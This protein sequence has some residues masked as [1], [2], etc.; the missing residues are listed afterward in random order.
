MTRRRRIDER[1]SQAARMV[2]A[3]MARHEARLA[4]AMAAHER[5][6]EAAERRM[7]HALEAAERRMSQAIR[8]G[9]Q[10]RDPIELIRAIKG[11]RKP[12][13]PGFR[14]G[15]LEGGEGVPAV[16]KP[17]PRPLAGAAAAPIE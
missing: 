4:S 7:A 1:S 13:P 3:H 17:K 6:M 8:A 10:V 15:D 11:R 2:E 9:E 16:P 14:R 5:A 12:P